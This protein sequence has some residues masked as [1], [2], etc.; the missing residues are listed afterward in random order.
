MASALPAVLLLG[1]DIGVLGW[2]EQICQTT[3]LLVSRI[4]KEEFNERIS[5]LRRN[6]LPTILVLAYM[7]AAVSGSGHGV[8]RHVSEEFDL[9]A[10]NL[11][12]PIPGNLV[13]PRRIILQAGSVIF[14]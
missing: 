1:L 2:T 11:R 13:N 9:R 6:L 4:Q 5:R 14:L 3:D 10:L 12:L 8:P 7:A